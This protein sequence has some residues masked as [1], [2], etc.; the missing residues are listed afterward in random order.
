V[1]PSAHE[2]PLAFATRRAGPSQ[3]SAARRAA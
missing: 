3:P 2:H 1:Q